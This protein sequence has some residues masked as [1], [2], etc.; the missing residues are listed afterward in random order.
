MATLYLLPTIEIPA[1]TLRISLYSD[2]ATL[3]VPSPPGLVN[4]GEIVERVN[5]EPG[6]IELEDV[7]LEYI[8]NHETYPQ[9][10]WQKWLTEDNPE[11][12]IE[13]AEGGSYTSIFR[14]YVTDTAPIS[15]ELAIIGTTPD[16]IRR[17]QFTAT[18]MLAKLKNTTIGDSVGG[19]TYISTVRVDHSEV[20]LASSMLF[21]PILNF[22]AAMV[23]KGFAQSYDIDDC[24]VVTNV[25][26]RYRGES[27]DAVETGNLTWDELWINTS[28]DTSLWFGALD[29]TT[30]IFDVLAQMCKG[31]GLVAR[32]KFDSGNARHTIEMYE[33]G[34]PRANEVTFDPAVPF[35]S[36][37]YQQSPS[38]LK[39]GVVVSASKPFWASPY[40]SSF[41]VDSAGGY[42]EGDELPLSL[43]PDLAL[44]VQFGNYDSVYPG[45]RDDLWYVDTGASNKEYHIDEIEFAYDDTP[46]YTSTSGE[47]FPMGEVLARFYF[48]RFGDGI[49]SPQPFQEYLRGYS[50]IKATESGTESVAYLQPFAKHSITGPEG[51]KTYIATEVRKDVLRDRSIVRWMETK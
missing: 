6:V 8:D 39:E 3:T 43:N 37:L 41:W 4:I 45:Q 25:A 27:L 7:T 5:V 47:D 13:L 15:E 18:S 14:G 32:Y 11:I 34:W 28:V 2:D 24:I 40:D 20:G 51:T 21:C 12:L 1:G 16:V 31:L 17:G 29:S 38:M 48:E 30:P 42:D 26:W 44:T 23:E 22:I 35:S 50:T 49:E 46:T 36:D 10:F 33:S 9:G 19:S